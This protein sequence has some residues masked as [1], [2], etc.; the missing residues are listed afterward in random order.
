V[1]RNITIAVTEKAA[2]W[3][4][5]KAAEEGTSVSKLVGRMLEGQ[6]RLSDGYR[7]AHKKW[8]KIGAIKGLDAKARL[9]RGETHARR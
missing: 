9:S 4:R 5:R 3:A 6:M 2:L 1:P 8:R 7:Q